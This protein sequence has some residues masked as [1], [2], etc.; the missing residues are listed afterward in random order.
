VSVKAAVQLT[1]RLGVDP[2][3]YV[4]NAWVLLLYIEFVSTGLVKVLVSL[5]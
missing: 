5:N 3:A 4:T 1:V 2:L